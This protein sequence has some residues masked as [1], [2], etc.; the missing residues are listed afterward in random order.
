M[1][2]EG[3]FVLCFAFAMVCLA[4]AEIESFFDKRRSP[5]RV[6][7]NQPSYCPVS[8]EIMAFLNQLRG[9]GDK[10]SRQKDRIGISRQ[11]QRVR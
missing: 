2:I 1:R 10:A 11:N 8:P 6:G 9:P 7:L 4:G 3:H 5:P